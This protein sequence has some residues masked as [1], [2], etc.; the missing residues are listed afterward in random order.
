LTL[1]AR[2]KS[3]PFTERLVRSFFARVELSVRCGLTPFERSHR[4]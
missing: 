4:H 1:S 3:C 2:L